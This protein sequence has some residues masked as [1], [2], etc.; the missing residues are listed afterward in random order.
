MKLRAGRLHDDYDIFEMIRHC[1][2]IDESVVRAWVTGD[3]FLR[4]LT[5]KQRTK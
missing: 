1:S 3:Q 4:Y 2:S 5:I